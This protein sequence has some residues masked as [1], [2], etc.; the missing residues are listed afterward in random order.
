MCGCIQR[1]PAGELPK[2]KEF[3]VACDARSIT[4]MGAER[5]YQF[6][7]WA[8]T[9]EEAIKSAKKFSEGWYIYNTTYYN[10]TGTNILPR[11]A[12]ARI[13]VP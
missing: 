2:T 1:K 13:E 3:I 4:D 5:Y 11:G 8:E 6:H 7:V 10:Y 12:I 9:E